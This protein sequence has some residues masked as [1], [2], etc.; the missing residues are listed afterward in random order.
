MNYHCLRLLGQFQ[1]LEWSVGFVLKLVN[2][3]AAIMQV[4]EDALAFL[5][6]ASTPQSSVEVRLVSLLGFLQASWRLFQCYLPTVNKVLLLG[7][8]PVLWIF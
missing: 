7:L 8:A 6:L 3:H 4:E 2:F 1:Y 5:Q